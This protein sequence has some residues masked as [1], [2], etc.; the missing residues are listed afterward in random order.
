M[1]WTLRERTAYGSDSPITR[2][3]THTEEQF[4]PHDGRASDSA[5]SKPSPAPKRRPSET[6]FRGQLRNLGSEAGLYL[7]RGA[8]TAAGGFVVTWATVWV[9]SRV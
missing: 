4:M 2:Q 3:K 9:Q 1:R 8:A 6:R 5:C 7:V